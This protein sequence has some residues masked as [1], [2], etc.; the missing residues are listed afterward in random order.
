MRNITKDEFLAMQDENKNI[1]VDVYAGWCS[2]C[3][4]LKPILERL[5]IPKNVSFYGI[6]ADEQRELVNSLN[7]R[8]LPTVLFFKGKEEIERFVGV[9]QFNTYKESLEKLSEL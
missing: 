7:V 3:T 5:E 1:M 2:P 6:D 9:R 8:S 4:I